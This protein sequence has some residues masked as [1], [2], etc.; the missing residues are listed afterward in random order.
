[1]GV[2]FFDQLK[3]KGHSLDRKHRSPLTAQLASGEYQNIKESEVLG[4]GVLFS[5]CGCVSYSSVLTIVC[6]RYLS[7][8]YSHS[9]THPGREHTRQTL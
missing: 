5:V 2:S 1:M 8:N 6:W 9:S 4:D 3:F 7:S